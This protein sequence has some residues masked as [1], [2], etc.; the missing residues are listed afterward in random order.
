MNKRCISPYPP[1]NCAYAGLSNEGTICDYDGYCDY[2]VP[3]DSR[4]QFSKQLDPEIAKLLE[5]NFMDLIW[6]ERDETD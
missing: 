6:E 1:L 3:R 5:N 4:N 2:Q